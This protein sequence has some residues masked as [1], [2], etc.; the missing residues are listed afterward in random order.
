MEKVDV[1][2]VTMFQLALWYVPD[3]RCIVCL[4]VRTPHQR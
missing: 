1:N 3:D 4:S 2:V